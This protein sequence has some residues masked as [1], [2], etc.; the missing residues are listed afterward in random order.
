MITEFVERFMSNKGELEKHFAAGHPNGY[1]DIVRAV[2]D[3]VK[4]DEF[5]SMDPSRIHVIDDGEYQGRLLFV[6]AASDCQPRDYWYV[7]VAYGSCSGCDTL[8]AI[9]DYSSDPPTADQIKDYMTL[10]LH[11]VQGLKKLDAPEE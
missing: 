3:V 6:I 8:K 5:D 1:L 9:H 11:I 4:G 7:T 2:V 10:A